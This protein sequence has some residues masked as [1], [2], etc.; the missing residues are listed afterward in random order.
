LR[1]TTD[2]L[3]YENEVL[4]LTADCKRC[5]LRTGIFMIFGVWEGTRDFIDLRYCELK[6]V[7]ELSKVNLSCVPIDL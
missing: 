3:T 7:V 6:S 4:L 2:R 1:G 5:F